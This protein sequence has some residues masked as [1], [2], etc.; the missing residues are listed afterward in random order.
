MPL[1]P[2]CNAP[3]CDPTS[4]VH[5]IQRFWPSDRVRK[6]RRHVF[7]K[8][9]ARSPDFAVPPGRPESQSA[10]D[11]SLQPFAKPNAIDP[12]RQSYGQFPEMT[13]QWSGLTSRPD[14]RYGAISWSARQG[15]ASLIPPI[16]AS[17]IPGVACGRLRQGS[18]SAIFRD[19]Y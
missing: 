7:A 9:T 15:P 10:I 6:S 3:P 19:Q 13:G 8:P 5:P 12:M 11:S 1:R 18:T 14:S 2:C 16:L 4:T 17:T